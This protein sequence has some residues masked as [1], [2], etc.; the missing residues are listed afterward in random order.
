LVWTSDHAP[1]RKAHT[2]SLLSDETKRDPRF[3]TS[4]LARQ[5]HLPLSVEALARS[6]DLSTHRLHVRHPLTA[7]A[8]VVSTDE[9]LG[10][11]ARLLYR[12]LQHGSAIFVEPARD[13]SQTDPAQLDAVFSGLSPRPQA[14][15][16]TIRLPGLPPMP[17]HEFVAACEWLRQRRRD[18]RHP[19]P[20]DGLDAVRAFAVRAAAFAAR[21]S[22]RRSLAVDPYPDEPDAVRLTAPDS[23]VGPSDTRGILVVVVSSGVALNICRRAIRGIIGEDDDLVCLAWSKERA[24]RFSCGVP[25]RPAGM[26]SGLHALMPS[27]Q[28]LHDLPRPLPASTSLASLEREFQS[29]F[30][31]VPASG[32]DDGRAVFPTPDR[33]ILILDNSVVTADT[34]STT[35]ALELQHPHPCRVTTCLRSYGTIYWDLRRGDVAP[36]LADALEEIQR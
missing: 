20:G 27:I 3:S 13:P 17:T 7:T 21:D 14:E 29:A 33:Y 1:Q 6:L 22:R 11:F 18:P 2:L 25:D 16:P 10:D 28:P 12:H 8:A 9:E 32:A 15:S 19:L 4:L 5:N 31:V 23:L 35:F 30:E 24:G 36:E 26:S 34:L